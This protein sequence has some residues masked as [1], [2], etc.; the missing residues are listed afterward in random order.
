MQK[1]RLEETTVRKD[2]MAALA[3]TRLR[4]KIPQLIQALTGHV[5]SHHCFLLQQLWAHLDELNSQ[6][7]SL[8]QQ[9]ECVTAPYAELITCLNTVST[10]V[11][12][13]L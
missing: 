12:R 2:Q 6:I 7:T 10:K 8:D 3:K 5:R 1:V 9:I 11:I 13:S 4:S